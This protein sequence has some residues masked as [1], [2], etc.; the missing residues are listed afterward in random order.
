MRRAD[1]KVSPRWVW[2]IFVFLATQLIYLYTLNPAFSN[3]DSAE[4]ITAG[5]I[6]GLQHPPGYALAAI[7]GRV[8]SLLPLGNFSFRVNW[9]ASLCASFDGA[10]LTF[11]IISLFRN[12]FSSRPF[13]FNEQ[14][15]VFC[16]VW[17]GLSLATAT[18]FWNNALSAKGGVYL[19]GVCFQQLIFLCLVIWQEGKNK[20]SRNVLTLSFF[21]TGLGLSNHWETLVLFI[22]ALFLFLILN[23]NIEIC[24]WI[25]GGAFF[26]L[27]ASALIFLPLRS[28]LNP[29]LNLGEPDTISNFWADIFRTYVS[30]REV[31]LWGSLAGLLKGSMG[32]SQFLIFF[33]Q[34][35]EN[36]TNL[37]LLNLG[38]EIGWASFGLVVIGITAWLRLAN[39]KILYFLLLSW[40]LIWSS[41]FSYYDKVENANTPLYMIKFSL[42]TDWVL[43]LLASL[44]LYFLL[45]KLIEWKRIAGVFAIASI[46]VGLMINIQNGLKTLDQKD[47]LVLYDY[48]QNLLKSLPP[49]SL[50]FADADEDYFSLYYLQQVEHR[51]PDVVM[52]PAFTLFET[53][54]T[55]KV[56]KEEPDLGLTASSM[57]FPDHFAR[58][59][60]ASS[61]LVVKNRNRRPIGFSNFGGT[62]HRYY[63][64]RQM[65][66]KIRSSGLIWVLDYPPARLITRLDPGQLRF[67]ETRKVKNQFYGSFDS[68]FK[69]YNQVGLRLS[70]N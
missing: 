58:I 35:I 48:G 21:L 47:R 3:D 23:G 30:F 12:L 54:G 31:S 10:L 36:K 5:A 32:L 61:E 37:L 53:W 62:F 13:V 57:T 20:I 29:A 66:I 8:L 17:G 4:T 70:E 59:I 46:A 52:I 11:L 68:I 64:D 49:H 45:S 25:Q 60:Y 34:L 42:S 27:G 7:F 51:R 18:V 28:Y 65:N 9:G 24:G 19:L 67:R 1:L 69:I 16:G 40:F 14:L 15:M 55:K 43:I 38:Q 56:E 39:K 22:P 50:F 2:P 44:G 26:I 63:L 41:I 33:H 6:L